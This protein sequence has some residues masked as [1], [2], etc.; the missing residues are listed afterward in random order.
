MKTTMMV[1]TIANPRRTTLAHLTPDGEARV[2]QAV[3]RP[4][5]AVDL[6]TRTANPNRTVLHSV[7]KPAGGSETSGEET[8]AA[9]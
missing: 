6:P 8:T 7:P 2:S 5:Y 9:Q 4:E 3:Q 1:R